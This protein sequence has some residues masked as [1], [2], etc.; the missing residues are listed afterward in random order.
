M[1]E[2]S[3]LSG[4]AIADV[5]KVDAIL[6]ASIANI[7]D[8]TIPSAAAFLLATYTGAATAY[9]TRR[10]NSAYTASAM[11]VRRD[12]DDT[13]QDIGFD[14][15]G[16]LDTSA[17]ATFVGSG[18][19]GHVVTWYDQSSNSNDASMSTVSLQPQIYDG[20]AVIT[21][22]G[23]AAI[24]FSSHRLTIDAGSMNAN[25]LSAFL[26]STSDTTSGTRVALALTKDRTTTCFV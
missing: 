6:K 15:N 12:S 18:N 7:N 3:K 22:N 2:I 20:T 14:S 5:A 10:L 17:L 16:D 9:S 21:E 24:G 23:K 11:R 1:A 19:I 26:V 25:L 13:E 8:L 4:V